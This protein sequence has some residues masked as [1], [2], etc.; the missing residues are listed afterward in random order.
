MNQQALLLLRRNEL[1]ERTLGSDAEL[2]DNGIFFLFPSKFT[3]YSPTIII[4]YTKLTFNV[5][6][7]PG[8]KNACRQSGF[9]NGQERKGWK[10]ECM[11]FG[12]IFQAVGFNK[13]G[14]EK[15]EEKKRR[16]L[17]SHNTHHTATT[18]SSMAE[19][20][21]HTS[22]EGISSKSLQGT[23]EPLPLSIP[24]MRQARLVTIPM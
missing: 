1:P 12:H 8:R 4:Q 7:T 22:T 23:G 24:H 11:F 21:S 18:S 15:R 20:S 2:F 19:M 10:I 17:T 5:R 9:T 16:K 14:G 3:E 13:F 6:M